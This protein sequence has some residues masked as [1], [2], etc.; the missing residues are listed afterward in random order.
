MAV[1]VDPHSMTPPIVVDPTIEYLLGP[2]RDR[3]PALDVRVPEDPAAALAEVDGPVA[4]VTANRAWADDYLPGL[5]PGDWVSTI[6]VGH[7]RFPTDVLDERGIA[8]TNNPGISATQ[9]AEHVFGMAFA[10]TRGLLAARENQRDR[11]WERPRGLTDLSGDACTVV[12]LG[13]IGEAVAARAAAFGMTVR[14]VKRDVDDHE[15]HADAVYAP[16]RLGEALEGA[17]LAVLALPLTD[18]TRAMVGA[19][20]LARTAGDAIVVNVGRGPT[21]DQG[22]LRDALEAG[23][24]GA[25]GLD[26]TDPEPLPA[27]SPLWD[28]DDVLVTPHCA[29]ASEKYPERFCARY[30]DQYDRWTAGEGLADRVV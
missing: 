18:A 22:A 10:F 5:E 28:R 4:F 29:G 16:D 21:L 25:A 11:E 9:I 20:E 2:V 27:E 19:P 15:G 7:E 14:G 3:R 1:A 23:T 26:V 30:L 12:G 8:F 24:V 6:G 17:R 13:A